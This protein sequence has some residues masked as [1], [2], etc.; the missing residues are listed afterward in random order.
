MLKV[1]PKSLAIF[2]LFILFTCPLFSQVGIG[3]TN[4]APGA[5][6]DIDSNNSGVLIPRVELIATNNQAPITAPTPEIGLLVFNTATSGIAPNN[7]TP[8]FYYWN[9]SQ[10]V[11]LS[12]AAPQSDKW[13]LFGNAGT[14]AGTNFIGTSD[15]QDFVIATDGTERMRV[16]NSGNIGIDIIPAEKLHVNGNLQLDGAFK[17]NGNS[18]LTSNVLMSNGDNNPASWSTF[19]MGNTPATTEI[20][21]YYVTINLG[22][23]GNWGNNAVITTIVNDPACRPGSSISASIVGW[24]SIYNGIIIRNIATETGQFRITMQNLTG[25]NL[26][27]A[28]QLAFIAFY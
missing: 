5:I 20:A 22:P 6:L 21:K 3:T 19:I 11:E 27:G 7:V 14:T 15:N 2:C 8:G 16:D 24:Q 23:P 10:W 25:S 12:G 28:L 26:S 13:D 4:P 17:P 9:G 18:G 1:I